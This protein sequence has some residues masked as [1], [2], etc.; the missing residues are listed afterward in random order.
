MYLHSFTPSLLQSFSPS[1]LLSFTP[2]ILL[3]F[4][5]SLLLSSTPSLTL[6]PIRDAEFSLNRQFRFGHEPENVTE[7]SV[8]S[9][10]TFSGMTPTK[11][12]STAITH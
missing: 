8:R 1:L 5:P 3:S 10:L 11:L 2:S 4:N 9:Q 12:G 7:E 6:E